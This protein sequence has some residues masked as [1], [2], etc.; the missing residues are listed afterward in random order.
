MRA[1]SLTTWG[2]VAG[3]I[4]LALF[5]ATLS[6]SLAEEEPAI[7]AGKV[8]FGRNC[9]ICHGIDGKGHGPITPML[10]KI[11]A[12]LTQ[13]AKKNGGEFPFWPTY[14]MI[15]GRE[16][17]DGHGGRDMP[18]WGERFRVEAGNLQQGAESTVRGRILEI[19]V[20]LMS[21]QAK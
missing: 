15:D 12:D 13:L 2:N 11:P 16:P 14:R 8:E 19:I 18:I 7:S 4:A 10:K 20:Y 17:I 6:T 9:G 1:Q 5:W 3:L 21:L